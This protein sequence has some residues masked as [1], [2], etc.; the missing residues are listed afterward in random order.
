MINY[1]GRPLVKTFTGVIGNI[2]NYYT[3]A[4]LPI[5]VVLRVQLILVMEMFIP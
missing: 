1:N 5:V 4:I 2:P 3:W